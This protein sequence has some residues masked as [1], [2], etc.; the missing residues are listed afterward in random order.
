[1]NKKCST[2]LS[3]GLFG[4]ACALLF[5]SLPKSFDMAK[6]DGA[7]V[8]SAGYASTNSNATKENPRFE[9]LYNTAPLT[10]YQPQHDD[11][12]TIK[13]NGKVTKLAINHELDMI[14]KTSSTTYTLETSALGEY[15][16]QAGD[17]YTIKG[18]FISQNHDY[19]L[20]IS[21]TSF[22]VSENSARSYF[23][24][25]PQ[26]CV[27]GGNA[28]MPPEPD[29]RWWFLFNLYSLEMKDAPQTG[30][31]YAYYPTSCDD[32]FI[33]G[34]PV[35]NI[36]EQVLRRRD[37]GGYMFYVCY[38][39]EYQGWASLLNVGSL[40]VFDGTFIYQGN[41][42]LPNNKKIGF[43]LNEVA[44][45]KIGSDKDD[46][47][48]VNFRKYLFDSINNK[49]DKNN[50]TG[51][52]KAEVARILADLENDIGEPETVREVYEVYDDIIARLESY[53]VDPTAAAEYL[54]QLKQQSIEE[55]QNYPV[56][57][58]YFP[59]QQEVIREHVS[60]FVTQVQTL[61][62][63]GDIVNLVN[64]TKMKID[65]VKVRK[66]VMKEAVLNQVPGYEKYLSSYDEVSLNELNLNSQTFHGDVLIRKNE[67][68][69]TNPQEPNQYNTFI[70]SEG[71]EKGNVV[72][73]FL[74][75]PHATP[76][77]GGNVMVNLRG[78]P[79]RGYKFGID[80][81][82][83]G[84]YITSIGQDTSQWI[85]G[86]QFI[87]VDDM[88]FLVEV[89]AIDFV[90]YD[91]TWL[92][93]KV[94]GEVKYDAVVSSLGICTNPR[95][96]IAA[97]DTYEFEVTENENKVTVINDYD[98]TVDLFNYDVNASIKSTQYCSIPKLSDDTIS[99]DKTIYCS[100]LENGIPY[101]DGASY[102]FYPSSEDVMTLTRDNV[103]TNVGD[104][105][106]PLIAKTSE[107][108]YQ[109]DIENIDLKDGD[110]LT[111][112]G[113]FSFYNEEARAK[114]S[115]IFGK[116]VLT[117]NASTKGWNQTCSLD[118]YKDDAKLQLDYFI[119]LNDYDAKVA[120]AVSGVIS[121]GKR[122]ISDANS[123]EEVDTILNE[124]KAKILRFKTTLTTLKGEAINGIKE[125]KQDQ[126]N[127]YR[128]DERNEIKYLRSEAI[129]NINAALS[130]EEI[131]A[132]VIEFKEE[133]DGLKTAA[134]YEQEEL[135]EAR[136]D[137]IKQIQDHYA[138]IDLKSY[139]NEK[140]EQLNNETMKA[141]SDLKD[142]GSIEEINEIVKQYISAHKVATSN[143]GL[144]AGIAIPSVIVLCG[145]GVLAFYL[146]RRRRK[147]A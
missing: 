24:A 71:N 77:S 14:S 107:T 27:D 92:F 80:T 54:N 66:T 134:Q 113:Q 33:D 10:K 65:A 129:A 102:E 37:N 44:F 140:R 16:P 35:A 48:V 5:S 62:N 3:L 127:D 60:S 106:S 21:E 104:I 132:I 19:I 55:I 114:E 78:I 93:V 46:Y 141:I 15:A 36:D 99:N 126:I 83:R 103:T 90:E 47:E 53:D 133:I 118:D 70:P 76:L 11:C 138:S 112:G 96:A 42:T 67:D 145:I 109:I 91:M 124:T 6:A 125:Y 43:S 8:I 72:L 144:I 89:G 20:D 9:M 87:F 142:A 117:Y 137:G 115:F 139:S 29:Q 111:I 147:N 128:L 120:L 108:D 1:M 94:D 13:R 51:E 26:Q 73:K 12:V 50:Y 122:Q 31:T 135:E 28:T 131:V 110:I 41:K 79:Y 22:V 146:V 136:R 23:I 34:K 81:N 143:G 63:K 30:D 101:T 86:T 116:M 88:T 69:T 68:L 52:A 38:Q 61:T 123:E 32:V 49:Y 57:E 97:N 64:Q 18:Q 2:F 17:V 7:T 85:G 59:E 25:L 82:T 121:K 95:V 100:S 84:C 98:G 75:E 105:S 130:E 4:F 119:N 56:Y 39:N 40:I 45:H 58:N 74:Y